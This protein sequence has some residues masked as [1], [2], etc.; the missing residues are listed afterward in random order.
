L[1]PAASAIIA[2]LILANAWS[3]LR[4]AVGILLE[5]TPRDVDMDSLVRDISSV[6]SVLGV[7]DLHV[8]SVSRNLRTMSAHV[9]TDEDGIS[10]GER[11][12][13]EINSALAAR[14]NIGHSTLQLECPT[15][16][17]QQLYCEMEDLSHERRG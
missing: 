10:E 9:L 14:Y 1:D 16:D 3:V 8:W 4:E 11:I 2:I 6:R 7:H 13:N 12:R 17:A 15:C 5:G